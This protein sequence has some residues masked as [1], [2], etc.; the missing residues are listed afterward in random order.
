[1]NVIGYVSEKEE[2]S[3]EEIKKINEDAVKAY[4]KPSSPNVPGMKKEED[5]E[6][7]E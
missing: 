3:E 1:M 6:S 2:L 7:E 5:S 4:S